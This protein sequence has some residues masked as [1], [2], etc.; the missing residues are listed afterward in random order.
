M[1]DL[2]S[3][4]DVEDR[5]AG[6]LDGTSSRDEVDRWAGRCLAAADDAP[7]PD[8]TVRW[9]LGILHGIDLR[10]GPDEPYLHDDAQVA[11]WLAELRDRFARTRDAHGGPP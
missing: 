8:D 2:P 7:T 4:R 11:G 5:F 9:A 6:L 3:R 10:G 1:S